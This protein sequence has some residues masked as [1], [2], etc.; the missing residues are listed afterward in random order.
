[1][2]HKHVF[3]FAFDDW[4]DRINMDDA[5]HPQDA[6]A[7]RNEEVATCADPSSAQTLLRTGTFGR[8][9]LSRPFPGCSNDESEQ[10]ESTVV[11]LPNSDARNAVRD[12]R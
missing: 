8:P 10:Q 2:N 6:A 11:T 3:I 7:L 4:L 12:E 1:M 5:V 9:P